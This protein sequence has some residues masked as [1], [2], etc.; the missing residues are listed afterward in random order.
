MTEPCGALPRKCLFIYLSEYP[1]STEVPSGDIVGA[2]RVRAYLC[3]GHFRGGIC[4]GLGISEG[5]DGQV[6]AWDSKVCAG[7][8]VPIGV[9]G[10]T[11]EAGGRLCLSRGRFTPGSD[12]GRPIVVGGRS[13]GFRSPAISIGGGD[14]SPG[15]H[16]FVE[17]E[18]SSG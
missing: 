1:R 3:G 13:G 6:C 14:V 10:G 2:R 18:T 11:P 17:G 15:G 7:V 5:D 9:G 4:C 16:Q 12:L 8:R